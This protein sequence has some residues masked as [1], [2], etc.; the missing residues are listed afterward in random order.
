MAH[1]CFREADRPPLLDPDD[2]RRMSM[3]VAT[4]IERAVPLYVQATEEILA[5][6]ISGSNRSD[7]DAAVEEKFRAELAKRVQE[8]LAIREREVILPLQAK[9]ARLEAED[10]RDAQLAVARAEVTVLEEKV[11][12]Y[13]KRVARDAAT[14]KQLQTSETDLRTQISGLEAKLEKYRKRV[15]RDAQKNKNPEK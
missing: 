3:L 12:K 8:G 14:I 7:V 2:L 11:E 1:P 4:T 10:T 13:K 15:A 9:I 5:K 6:K